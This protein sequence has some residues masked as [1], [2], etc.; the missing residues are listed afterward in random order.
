MARPDGGTTIIRFTKIVLAGLVAL[1]GLFGLAGNLLKLDAA[2]AMVRATTSMPGFEPGTAPP[3][4]TDSALIAGL[5][6]ALI[7]LG[8]LLPAV[9]CSI[10]ALRMTSARNQ[11]PE[12]WQRSKSLAI[13]GC[14]L[15][16][17]GL[18]LGWTVI[19][20][21]IFM[22]FRD[23]GLVQAA[24]AAFRYGGFI[25]LIGIFIAQRE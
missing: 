4:A 22:M 8:K 9:L 6:V 5:G 7:V 3:W 18:F 24:D 17:A 16:A 2:F 11:A 23:P 25:L 15:A 20:E 10:G 1:W 12:D 14:G 21:F 19:G 13:A